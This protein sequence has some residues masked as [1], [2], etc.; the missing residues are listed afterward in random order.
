[1]TISE[2][3]VGLCAQILAKGELAADISVLRRRVE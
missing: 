3:C 1:V 2:G